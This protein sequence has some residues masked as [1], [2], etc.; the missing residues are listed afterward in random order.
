MRLK[1]IS[2]NIWASKLAANYSLH[3]RREG[4]PEILSSRVSTTVGAII[5]IS[6]TEVVDERKVNTD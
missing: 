1:F 3:P 2:A 4:P 5:R 6:L